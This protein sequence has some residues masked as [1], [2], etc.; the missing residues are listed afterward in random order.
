M[1]LIGL[2][3]GIAT[4]KSTVARM[5]AA[6]GATVIDA[7]EL[8]REVV[9]P[10]EPALVDIVARFG[11]DVVNPDGTLDRAKLAGI[12]FADASARRD[13]EHITH[14]RITGLMQS[15]IADA[16]A[17]D[18]LLIVVDVPLLFEGER[19]DVFEGTLVVYAPR[20][21]QIQRIMS[22]DS[23]SREAAEQRLDAQLPVDEKRK[24]A[25][26][27]I[28]NSGDVA[29]TERRVAAWWAEEVD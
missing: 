19:D 21:V 8:A 10:G 25:T 28:D 7:D 9:R 6:R 12:V 29:E 5:L 2:T 20:D 22:R 24:R 4:G 16:L 26:W 14:P 1:H 11:A 3:G 17:R 27:V 18:A 13:L 15:R 23:L